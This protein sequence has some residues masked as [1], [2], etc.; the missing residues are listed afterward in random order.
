MDTTTRT[1]PPPAIEV[2]IGAVEEHHGRAAML[3]PILIGVGIVV[4]LIAL[5]FGVRWIAY[6][7]T[8]ETTDDATIDADQVQVTSKISER[9]RSILVDTNQP[10]R[11]GQ[12]LIELDS[13]DEATKVAQAR[14]AVTA[15]QAQ[16]QAAEQNV[17]LTRDTQAA[18]DQQAAGSIDQ[19]RAAI[20]SASATARSS[21]QEIAAAQAT[22]AATQAQYKAAQDALPGASENLHKAQADLRRAQSLVSTGDEAPAQ[23]DAARATEKA[24]SSQYQQAQA[25]VGAAAANVAEAQQKVDAQ[26]FAA[27]STQAQIGEQ[28]ASLLSAQG[29]LAESNAPSRVPAQQAQAD[30]ARAQIG[31][32]QAQLRTAQDQL[33]Y[34]RV[35]SPIDGYVGQKNVEVGQTVSP[36]LSLLTLV[37]S[38]HVYVTANY[39][40]TQIGRMKVGQEV[41]INIDAYK[42]IKFTGHV[43]NL[44]PASQNTFSLVPAQNA[45]G[46]FVKVTQR[47]PVRIE[48][49]HPDPTY[50]L[51]PG[52][53]VE[54]SVKVK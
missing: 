31:S 4:L 47:L 44:S 50:A 3:R 40:E 36:G 14:A 10:V 38:N 43:E 16:A 6:A 30:A 28:Q 13:Q 11:K 34:T 2:P 12:L 24:A 9:V 53:S 19:A 23:L 7:T 15:Q 51:R 37:P 33:S 49:D 45:T 48:F 18:Q 17:A 29:H 32:L 35:V 42:G 25:S 21:T 54:T 52:M 39:K 5:V 20:V 26:R 27:D 22:L 1:A 8:H 41:D 46:N